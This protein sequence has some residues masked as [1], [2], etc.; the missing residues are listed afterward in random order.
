MDDI[1]QPKTSQIQSS[2]SLSG[3]EPAIGSNE[4][5][6]QQQSLV[7]QK[8][9]ELKAMQDQ[10]ESYNQMARQLTS[11]REM[12]VKKLAEMDVHIQEF[13]RLLEV[14]KSQVE[15]KDKELRG[16]RT[17]LQSLKNEEDELRGKIEKER[18]DISAATQS[19]AES[20][21]TDS[22]IKAKLT[23]LQQFLTSTNAAIEDIERAITYKDSMKLTA[24]FNQDLAPPPLSNNTLLTNGTKSTMTS[25][26]SAGQNQES[27][28]SFNDATHDAFES[29]ANYDPF[30]NDDPFDGDDPFKAENINVALPEDDP[31]N[32]SSSTA[33]PGGFNSAFDD[34]FVP[35]RT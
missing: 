13:N 4:N 5:L 24:I 14:E 22:Q 15:A 34:P 31:F 27:G 10:I 21:L 35:K 20:E 16:K 29:S 3:S 6:D 8:E 9:L 12:A 18:L 2:D 23:E 28:R 1:L 32:P 26:S 25:H 11:Q 19:L 33:A 30:A 7:R 17:K